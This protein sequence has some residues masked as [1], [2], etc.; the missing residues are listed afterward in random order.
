MPEINI[1]RLIVDADPFAFSHSIAEGGKNAGPDTWAAANAEASS[2]PLPAPEDRQSVR[3]FFAGFGAWE[4]DE[5][6]AWSDAE[7]DAL[8]LQYASGD[9]REVQTLCPGDGLGDID[10][11]EAEVLSEAGTIGGRLFASG[12]NLYIYLG[13]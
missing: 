6:A 11:Q 1:T 2:R 5:I 13:D 7:L 8:V 12:A 3:N 4:A 10:W 9:L